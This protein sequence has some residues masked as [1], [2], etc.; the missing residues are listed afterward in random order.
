[1]LNII[2]P[3]GKGI[4]PQDP[5]GQGKFLAPRGEKPHR[6]TD[7]V[8]EPG[9]MVVSPV[10]GKVVR[11][12]WPYKGFSHYRGILITND[13]ALFKMFYLTPFPRIL[14]VGY[15]LKQGQEIGLAQDISKRKEKYKGMIPHIHLEIQVHGNNLLSGKAEYIDPEVLL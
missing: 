1:M 15:K 13:F 3:T 11:E 6:G 12:A 8:C 10:D 9:Q 4:R 2:S 7:F 5:W 14:H